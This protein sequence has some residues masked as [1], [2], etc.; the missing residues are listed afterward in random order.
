MMGKFCNFSE[1]EK[2]QTVPIMVK[3]YAVSI[4]SQKGYMCD[5]FDKAT[6]FLSIQYNSE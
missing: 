1:S 4:F 2:R 5:T 6:D 3:V